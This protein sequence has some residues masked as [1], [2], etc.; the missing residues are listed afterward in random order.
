MNPERVFQVLA[1]P[2]VS[3]KAALVADDSN[4]YVFKVAVDATKPEIRKAVEQ[5][6]KV[7]VEKVTTMKVKG[8]VKRNRYGYSTRPNWKKAYVSVQPGQ[9]IDL[10]TAD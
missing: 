8:K 9:E 1:G 6:F 2:H 4:Q 7:N 5:L 3:E 10:T